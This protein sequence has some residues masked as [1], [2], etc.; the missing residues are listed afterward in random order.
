M[1]L[2]D[3]LNQ[4]KILCKDGGMEPAE[5]T[6]DGKDFI[7]LYFT[8]HWCP[9][10]RAFTPQLADW[11]TKQSKAEII[12]VSSDNDKESYQEYYGQMP[13]KAMSFDPKLNEELRDR[14]GVQ[15][16]P[17]LVILDASSGELVTDEARGDINEDVSVTFSQWTPEVVRE[18]EQKKQRAKARLKNEL[19]VMI[20]EEL[21]KI[22]LTGSTDHNMLS[23]IL[24]KVAAKQFDQPLPE[25]YVQSAASK[26]LA[27]F[28]SEDGSILIPETVSQ[29]IQESV[30]PV[31]DPGQIDNI[32]KVEVIRSIAF[33]RFLTAAKAEADID[34]EWAANGEAVQQ[35]R[36]IF[37]KFDRD[38]DERLSKEEFQ[39]F[40]QATVQQDLEGLYEFLNQEGGGIEA[41]VLY[42]RVY[43]DIFVGYR[44][45]EA[46]T[47]LV[48]DYAALFRPGS[49][50]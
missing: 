27:Q 22:M 5:C 49:K 31:T 6:V 19:P 14:F 18:K 8:A 20:K 40:L 28:G 47:L 9:P 10:C 29:K 41:R 17:T 38:A 50:L 4:D 13:W 42:G 43:K 48:N 3:L 21:D 25:K 39:A 46:A 11:Y 36:A 34:A 7:G 30:E 26:M 23:D 15:G 1:W 2:N 16:I 45:E 24:E 44:G 33:M 12:F 37:S 32:L 35:C